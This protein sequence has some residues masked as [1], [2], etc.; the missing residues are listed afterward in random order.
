M[1]NINLL[2]TPT[3]GEAS[4][5]GS[6]SPTSS[7]ECK[8]DRDTFS[9]S[10]NEFDG[11]VFGASL[12][13][14]LR[15]AHE[16]VAI[17]QNAHE[18]EL[19]P[20]IIA[21]NGQYLKENA[22]DTI[23]IFRIAGS[24]KRVKE[25]QSIYSKPS[26]FGRKFEDWS[27]FNVHDIAT[28]LKRYLNS[29]SE[30]LVPLA[31]YDIFRNPI[32]ENPKI[33]E[34]KKEIIEKYEDIY[35]LL[36]QPNRH[37]ILYLVGLLSLFAKNEVKNL[38][39]ASNLAAIVQPSILSHPK[40]E[41]DPSEYEVSRTVIE[42]LIVHAS[43]IIPNEAKSS[44]NASPHSGMVAKFSSVVVPEMAIDSDDEEP[45]M[46]SIDNHMLPKSRAHSDSDNFTLQHAGSS[47][48]TDLDKNGLSVPRTYKGRTLSAGSLSPKLNKLLGG[49]SSSSSSSSKDPRERS[50]RSKNKNKNKQHRQS[51]L[52]R[53]TSPSRTVP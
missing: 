32:L 16:E 51:W 29:L 26:D 53:L 7:V 33:D 40:H 48:P 28:L 30:P 9:N 20:I 3:P 43:D 27:D 1:F 15:V 38:M 22:L 46:P 25:L 5:Q 14:S 4:P 23:G 17:Q 35:M 2:S 49:H 52:R 45:F 24:N 21:K 47:S 10:Q 19:V 13:N 11:K 42:F 36:P 18:S 39:P 8:R 44:K 12:K 37:L 31:L 50:P 6:S 41:M 34:R